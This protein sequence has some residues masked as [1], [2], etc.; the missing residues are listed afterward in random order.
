MAEYSNHIDT[1]PEKLQELIGIQEIDFIVESARNY[2]KSHCILYIALSI[3]MF[4][5]AV[6]WSSGMT[7]SSLFDLYGLIDENKRINTINQP[8]MHILLVAVLLTTLAV[9]SFIH[10]ISIYLRKGGL[11][12]GTESMLIKYCKDKIHMNEWRNFT[13][14]IQLWSKGQKGNV[15]LELKS[16]QEGFDSF[17]FQKS[18]NLNKGK[19]YILDIPNPTAIEKMCR[20]R[21]KSTNLNNSI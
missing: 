2:P 14:N 6:I 20:K 18:N 7:G 4:V 21:I 17:D 5:F 9:F 1:L 3:F 19:I 13:G 12:V 11:F 15:S 8:P 10:S 16:G